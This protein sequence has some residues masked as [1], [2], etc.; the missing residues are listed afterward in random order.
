LEPVHGFSGGS[1]S[2]LDS[3]ASGTG[4]VEYVTTPLSSTERYMVCAGAAA[5]R[6]AR[7]KDVRY[8]IGVPGTGGSKAIGMPRIGGSSPAPDCRN[9]IPIIIAPVPGPT[10]ASFEP[11]LKADAVR[12]ET[13]G[14][15]ITGHRIPAK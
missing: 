5:H 12:I 4:E 13:R 14:V 8:L 2:G 11:A 6:H 7:R 3:T 10:A 15:E 9:F 1:L